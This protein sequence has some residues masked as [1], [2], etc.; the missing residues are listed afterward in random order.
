[1]LLRCALANLLALALVVVTMPARTALAPVA[2]AAELPAAIP[3]IYLRVP[4][5][6]PKG[7]PIQVLVALHGMGG[8]GEQFASNFL[9][10]SDRNHWLL[11]APT[12]RYGDWTDPNQVATEDPQLIRWLGEYLDTLS[13][14]T[15]MSIKPRVLLLG[16][17]RGAQLAHRFALFEPQRVLAVAALAA[18]TYTLP[19]ERSTQDRMI[20]F[21]FGIGDL[22][23]VA[24]HPFSRV[25]L[26]EDT[27]FWLGVGTED[28]NPGDLPRAWDEYLGTNRVQ[29]AR[30]FQTAL[31]T[32][33]ARSVLVGFQGEKHSLTA[34]MTASACSFLRSLDLANTG[35]KASLGSPAVLRA[36]R[37]RGHF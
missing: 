28:N 13:A 21:P 24:G 19:V 5:D 10:E 16:H 22:N 7:T 23:A 17:S 18:G 37:T 9:A 4:R 35:S 14:F 27:E 11:V 25:K 29:R 1:M 36:S 26:I 34:D 12:I 20:R 2:Q 15:G 3:N 32:M 30:A 8:N 6:V 33:G 31:H